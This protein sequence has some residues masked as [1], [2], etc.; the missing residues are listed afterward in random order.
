MREKIAAGTY[1]PPVVPVRRSTAGEIRDVVTTQL[2]DMR[3]HI[4]E[5]RKHVNNVGVR[6]R[7]TTPWVAEL[8]ALL[9]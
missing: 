2:R 4:E 5:H 8:D 9:P 1:E 7:P 3:T 6:G